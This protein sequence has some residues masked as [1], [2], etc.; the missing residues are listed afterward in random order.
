MAGV[1]APVD[2]GGGGG[3]EGEES[4]EEAERGQEER[5]HG[6]SFFFCVKEGGGQGLVCEGGFLLVWFG[7][8]WD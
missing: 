7:L 6:L 3:D 1:A 2:G 4:G 8:V 5:F